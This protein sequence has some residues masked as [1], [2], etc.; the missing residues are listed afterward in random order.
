MPQNIDDKFRKKNYQVNHNKFKVA[1]NGIK[2]VF[3]EESSFRY[4]TII[5]VLTILLGLLVG[6]SKFEWLAIA[7][8]AIIV[9]TFE[10]M[11]TA[12]E[13]VVDLI[14]PKYNA[15]AGKVKDISAAAVLVST[16]GALIIG[17]II[18][19]PKIMSFF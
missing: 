3:F 4:Q 11:N 17:A 2:V 8:A 15:L 7:F 13:N 18:F 5:L 19:Y 6:L 1:F 16:I 10:I 12:I 14:S 9:F